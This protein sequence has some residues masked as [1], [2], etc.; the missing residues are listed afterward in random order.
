MISQRQSP[1]AKQAAETRPSTKAPQVN[2]LGVI[3]VYLA[4]SRTSGVATGSTSST[5]HHASRFFCVTRRTSARSG[6]SRR[7][8]QLPGVRN[9]FT[10]SL[11]S[12]HARHKK[13]RV[14]PFGGGNGPTRQQ[15]Q[16]VYPAGQALPQRYEMTFPL[17]KMC[18]DFTEKVEPSCL[19][20]YPPLV[21]AASTHRSAPPRPARRFRLDPPVSSASIP[22]PAPPR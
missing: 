2:W 1:S 6:M 14:Q 16:C 4:V 11:R 7:M 8:G 18:R 3:L 21:R 20:R 10:P 5:V 19:P 17:P 15:S 22:R 9:E 13:R 12:V